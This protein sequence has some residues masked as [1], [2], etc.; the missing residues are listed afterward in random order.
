MTRRRRITLISLLFVFAIGLFLTIRFFV[1]TRIIPASTKNISSMSLVEV[2]NNKGKNLPSTAKS[3]RVWNN[4]TYILSYTAVSGYAN[5]SIS[6]TPSTTTV[7]INPDYSSEKITA[8]LD[9]ATPAIITALHTAAPTIDQ[10]YT[11]S[12][13]TLMNWGN[14]YFTTLVYKG[15]SD[16]ESSDTLVTG[17]QK[18]NNEWK[19]VLFPDIIFT[20]STHP[21]VSRSFIDAANKYR[22][23]SVKPTAES[24]Y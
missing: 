12:K 16:D 23:N 8:L 24:Y 22:F 19:V 9:E 18:I 2:G 15:S 11:I 20:T 5:G 1:S 10:Y 17:L 7:K 3:I 6:I 21:D 4:R 14:W 13:G